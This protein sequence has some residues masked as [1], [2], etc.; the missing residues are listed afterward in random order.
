VTAALDAR[1]AREARVAAAAVVTSCLIH[2]VKCVHTLHARRVHAPIVV[3]RASLDTM[4]CPVCRVC[5]TVTSA[6]SMRVVIC[7]TLESGDVTVT[8]RVVEGVIGLC[9]T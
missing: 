3:K 8:Q 7:V 5:L 6:Q 2:F 1:H 4:D 9:V